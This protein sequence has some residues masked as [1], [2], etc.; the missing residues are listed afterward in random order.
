MAKNGKK[1]GVHNVKQVYWNRLSGAVQYISERDQKGMHIHKGQSNIMNGMEGRAKGHEFVRTY[2][3][4]K[5]TAYD[6]LEYVEAL[7]PSASGAIHMCSRA[8]LFKKLVHNEGRRR[9]AG[10][11][12]Y[13]STGYDMNFS[14]NGW[15]NVAEEGSVDV[16]NP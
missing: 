1:K 10:K 2:V 9:A 16:H 5:N 11:A 12:H 8:K 6:D 7:Q 14:Y 3:R 15:L 13:P 4:N